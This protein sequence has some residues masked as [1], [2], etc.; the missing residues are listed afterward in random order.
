M[1]APHAGA[2]DQQSMRAFPKDFVWGAATAAYQVEGAW[3]EDGK[4]ESIWDRF[5]HTPGRVERG[6]TG[7]VACD[8]YRRYGEDIALMRALGLGAYRFSISW[9]RIFPAGRGEVNAKGLDHYERLVDALLAA[10]IAP[11]VTLYHWDL[12]LTLESE[13]GWRERAL[14][15]VFADYAAAVLRRLGDRVKRWMTLNEPWVVA[16][17]GHREGVHAPGRQDEREAFLVA[18]HLMLAHG[19]AYDAIKAQRADARVGLTNVHHNYVSLARE[20]EAAWRIAYLHAEN[21]GIFLDPALKGTYPQAVL[22]RLGANA[23]PVRDEDL[24]QMRRHDFMG[25]QYYFD[26]VLAQA[27]P[28]SV[29]ALPRYSFYDYTEVGWPV[30]PVGL[31]E[32]I[33]LLGDRY[34]AKEI[35]ITENGSAWPDVLGPDGRVRDAKRQDYLKKHLQQVHRAIE[36]GAPVTGYFCWSLM[37]NFEWSLGYRP[38]F[39]LVYTEFASQRRYIKDSGYLYRDIIRANGLPE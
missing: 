8:Q 1:G 19:K 3:R 35:V 2:E 37:D 23:P 14:C 22:D 7:D 16:M 17:L 24:A 29:L 21:N 26:T 30:T 15:D 20:E 10:G 6:E 9:P 27:G 18:Y 39:G 13:G 28:S 5:S 31:F 11:W 12:P 38:R 33:M 32:Q 25:V 36:A 34:A 4:G